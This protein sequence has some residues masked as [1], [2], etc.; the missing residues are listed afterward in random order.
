[1]LDPATLAAVRER[2]AG[3]RVSDTS[4]AW[5]RA[6]N[7][8]LDTLESSLGVSVPTSPNTRAAPSLT[9]ADV[10]RIAREEAT[11]TLA[12]MLAGSQPTQLDPPPAQP[13]AA[14]RVEAWMD[15]VTGCVTLIDP[16]ATSGWTYLTHFPG[17]T[18]TAS[19]ERMMAAMRGLW[20]V[21]AGDHSQKMQAARLRVRDFLDPPR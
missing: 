1:M 12:Q 4:G 11:K 17:V 2:I 7:S 6:W 8:A 20:E 19:A 18:D 21:S 5:D 16:G 13:A 15:P 9:D 3:L 14:K 10:R